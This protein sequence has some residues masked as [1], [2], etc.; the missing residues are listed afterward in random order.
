MLYTRE[1]ADQAAKDLRRL[2][3]GSDN[4]KVLTLCGGVPMGP[5]IERW[6]TAP[7]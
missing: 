7:R 2:A 3:R 5:Q 6:S 1:L 4:V